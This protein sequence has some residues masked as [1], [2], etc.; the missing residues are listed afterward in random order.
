MPIITFAIQTPS[1]MS[2]HLFTYHIRCLFLLQVPPAYDSDPEITLA[3]VN[4]GQG[5]K[6]IEMLDRVRSN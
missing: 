4:A 2:E 6:K 3:M 1:V 5:G